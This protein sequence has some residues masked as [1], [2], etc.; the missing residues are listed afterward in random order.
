[1]KYTRGVILS[2]ANFVPQGNNPS[3]RIREEDKGKRSWQTTNFRGHSES[4][5][6]EKRT[7]SNPSNHVPDVLVYVVP[8][9]VPISIAA[10]RVSLLAIL[11]CR[12]PKCCVGRF[13]FSFCQ[14]ELLSLV[15]DRAAG[16]S[17]SQSYKSVVS[18]CLAGRSLIQSSLVYYC[19]LAT[20]S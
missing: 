13:R 18:D 3:N 12:V 19:L 4:I 16:S 10:V 1:M 15:S 5:K 14:P 17:L 6:S 7:S 20:V 11:A 8:L 2:G 9:R